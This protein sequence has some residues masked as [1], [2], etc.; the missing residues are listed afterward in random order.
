M[1]PPNTIL[2][3]R[4]NPWLELGLLQ[5][6]IVDRANAR[7]AHIRIA[8]ASS[9]HERAAD[10]AETIFHVVSGCDSVVLAEPGKLIF[11]SNVFEVTVLDDKVGRKHAARQ[12]SQPS[13]YATKGIGLPRGDLVTVGA[14]A[15]K[16]IYKT[17]A[18]G[19][20]FNLHR[21]AEARRCCSS[22]HIAMSTFG[23]QDNVFNHIA[24]A[25]VFFNRTKSCGWI[26]C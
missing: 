9:V 2:R 23:R 18:L 4:L 6:D 21:A 25:E 22:I 11:T 19:G 1:Q 7:D 24:W 13:P 3:K 16:A 10:A 20:N 15:D 5:R 14:I 17:V 8:A 12:H 26:R